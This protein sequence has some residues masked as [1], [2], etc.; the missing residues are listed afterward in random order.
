MTAC[1]FSFR[2][3]LWVAFVACGSSRGARQAPVASL[4]GAPHADVDAAAVAASDLPSASPPAA[5]VQTQPLIDMARWVDSHPSVPIFS[6][7]LSRH[8]QLVFELYSSGF[9]R[10]EA[11]YL[12]STTKSVTSA[13]VGAALDRGLLPGSDAA[14]TDV[15]PA[16]L[17]GDPA[18]RARFRG[19]SLKNVMG[20]SVLDA[21]E[22]PR[23]N[24]PAAVLRGKQFF[25]APN[26]VAFALTQAL[27]PSPGVSFQYNAIT[28]VLAGGAVQ[29]ATG[30]RL[31]DFAT[32]TLFAPMGF[33]NAEWMHQDERGLDLPS[34]GLRLR[35][36]DMQ[37]FGILYLNHGLWNGRRLISEH[38]VDTSWTPYMHTG[39]SVTPGYDN[40]GWF[41]WQRDDWGTRVHWTSGWRGQFIAA[42]PDYDAVFTMTAYIQTGDEVAVLGSLMT[43]YVIPALAL[44]S[45]SEDHALE[46]ALAREL[47]AVNRDQRMPTNPEPRMVPSVEPKG[48][49]RPFD[50]TVP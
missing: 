36:M 24:S 50:P 2:V 7:L 47:A 27:L 30:K 46:D 13:I 1:S 26:R 32:E 49:P 45:A 34:Y 33:K 29:Y 14:L 8:G 37:K 43:H 22:P 21:D 28:P 11:H 41:W 3:L 18:N 20:M 31:F 10:D 42:M 12:M 40:Y 39:P 25:S 15:V 9:T 19:V 23:D 17:Y 6:L 4:T 38:W 44:G 16:A 48:T 35:P 5:G